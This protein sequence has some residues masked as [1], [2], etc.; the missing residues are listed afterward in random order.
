MTRSS[1]LYSQPTV[2]LAAMP[3]GMWFTPAS[4]PTGAFQATLSEGAAVWE[5]SY[6]NVV[7]NMIFHFG[8]YEKAEVLLLDRL[9]VA[10]G[11]EVLDVGANLGNHTLFVARHADVVHAVEPWPPAV[12]RLKRNLELN[13]DTRNVRVHELGYANEPGSL[14]FHPPPG[15]ALGVGTFDDTFLPENRPAPVELPLV[16]ADAHLA[17]VGAGRVGVVKCDIEGFERYAFEGMA[18]TLRR[19]RPA[20]LFELNPTEGGFTHRA[21]L[22]QTF[23]T[24]YSFYEV[25]TDP[26]WYLDLVFTGW[27]YGSD[28]TG[29][30]RI[31]PLHGFD[32]KNALALPNERDLLAAVQ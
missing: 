15:D 1:G 27:M 3:H 19:D 22:E 32:R 11:G 9:A 12:A 17:E 30:Y 5:G 31:R 2:A 14:P 4:A 8:L 25:V 23:P 10:M 7:D 26:P 6:D 21:Q 28:A 13:P 24:D 20:V 18:Q 29:R 16:T